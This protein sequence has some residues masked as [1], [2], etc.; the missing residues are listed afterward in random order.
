[1]ENSMDLANLISSLGSDPA[2]MGAI[3]ELLKNVGNMGIPTVKNEPPPIAQNIISNADIP[4]FT[5][6]SP[7]SQPDRGISCNSG[8]GIPPELLKGLIS[9]L[10]TTGGNEHKETPCRHEEG[11]LGEQNAL[12]KLLGGKAES[13]NRIRLLNALRPYL[14]EERRCKLDLLLK[15]LRLAELG[16]LSGLLNSV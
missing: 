1:M 3:T 14:S 15:L 5:A 2:I 8:T 9:A 16:K 4:Q 12:Y 6:P 10:G 11:N 13:E 7:Y